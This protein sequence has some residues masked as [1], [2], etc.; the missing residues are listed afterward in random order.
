MLSQPLSVLRQRAERL[1]GLLDERAQIERTTG[2]AGGGAMPGSAIPSFGVAIA[3]CGVSLETLAARLRG[4][5]PP[6]IGRIEDGRLLLDMLTVEESDLESIAAA[7]RAS[8][9]A[10]GA[11]LE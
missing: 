5:R 9:L 7:V 3:P 10:R 4:C 6:V 11:S 2:Y 8:L 1:A